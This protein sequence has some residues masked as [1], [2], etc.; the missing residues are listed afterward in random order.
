[1]YLTHQIF[2]D[3]QHP[4]AFPTLNVSSHSGTNLLSSRICL[5]VSSS[6]HFG[7]E[8]APQTP[9]LSSAR[10]HSRL[11]SAG[12]SMWYVRMLSDLQRSQRTFPFEL[13]FPATNTMT[14]CSNANFE[15][16]SCLVATCEHMVLWTVSRQRPLNLSTES[17]LK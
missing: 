3:Y 8:V 2:A 10:N 1:M 9:T 7:V 5:A 6:S 16:L 13:A 11:I 12:E 4:E 14:S 15:S 17:S